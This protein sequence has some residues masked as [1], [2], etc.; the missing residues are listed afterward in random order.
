MTDRMIVSSYALDQ[1]IELLGSDGCDFIIEI[2]DTL[3]EDAPRNFNELEQSLL[4]KNFKTFQRAAHTLKT[5][6]STVG[7]KDL[8]DLFLE[9]E[10][11]GSDRDLSAVR[12][13]ISAGV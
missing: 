7:A 10:K 2:I 13:A 5:N 3:I 9:L 12:F 4:E 6:C 1:Y 11:R 8:A